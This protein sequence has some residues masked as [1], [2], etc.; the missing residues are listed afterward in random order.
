MTP[1]FFYDMEWHYV[2]NHL[3]QVCHSDDIDNSKNAIYV[4]QK[5][6]VE[7]KEMP[8]RY[9]KL[10]KEISEF[11]NTDIHLAFVK[12]IFK[13]TNG[14]WISHKENDNKTRFSLTKSDCS[15]LEIEYEEGIEAIPIDLFNTF[16][17]YK[18]EMP[19]INPND[20]STCV[21]TDENGLVNQISFLIKGFHYDPHYNIIN[22]ELNINEQSSFLSSRFQIFQLRKHSELMCPFDLFFHKMDSGMLGYTVKFVKPFRKEELKNKRINDLLLILYF[23]EKQK[24]SMRYEDLLQEYTDYNLKMADRFTAYANRG[25]YTRQNY[26]INYDGRF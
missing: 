8:K 3:I 4:Y 21:K 25:W 2:P 6:S 5:P 14:K 22:K 11:K 16:K 23:D 15:F 20:L 10:I 19:T 24:E 18:E 1:S 17:E 7:D 26:L 9:Y 13:D 12:E